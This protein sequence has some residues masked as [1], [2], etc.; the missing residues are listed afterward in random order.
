MTSLRIAL[1][2][3]ISLAIFLGLAA[4]GEG[5]A[6]RFFASPPFVA[7]TLATI[8]LGIAALFTRGHVG[9]GVR[10]DRSNRWVLAAVTVLGVALAFLPPLCDRFDTLTFGGQAVR[11]LGV[12]LY[13]AGGVLRLA[14]VFVL[15]RR[16][17]GLVAIQPDHVL[18]TDG[19]YGVIRHPSYLGLLVTC[20]GWS[21]VFR[22]IVG[23]ALTGA[24]ALVLVARMNAEE[25][26][27][28]ET[29]GAE[30][31]AWRARTWRLVP[32]VY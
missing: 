31:A 30:Y 23:L 20:V 32:W 12:A 13:A 18:V 7:V 4:A 16:F 17:S 10:E 15:G 25:R 9:P 3:T 14:P 21:L 2:T 19:L 1:L 22:S 28:G 11:W 29:F 27:L 24:I 5:G 8:A 6:A 26:L